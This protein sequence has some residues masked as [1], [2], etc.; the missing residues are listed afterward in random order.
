MEGS[1]RTNKITKKTNLQMTMK[2]VKNMKFQGDKELQ[3]S[4]KTVRAKLLNLKALEAAEVTSLA[5][6]KAHGTIRT[7]CRYGVCLQVTLRGL[8]LK[9]KNERL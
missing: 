1:I 6:K 7:K 5:T 4:R 3:N 8:Q 9:R 2:T